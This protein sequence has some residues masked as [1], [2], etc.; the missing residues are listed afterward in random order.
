MSLS[1]GE[2]I[3]ALGTLGLAEKVVVAHASLRAFGWVEGGAGTVVSALLQTCGA[4]FMPTHTYKTMLTPQ[5]GPPDNGIDYAR[6]AFWNRLA[7]PYHPD[8]PADVLMGII[9][10]TLRQHPRARRSMHP[11]LSFAGVNA[12]DIL[13]T[14][15]LENPFAPLRAAA[16]A[17]A[18]VLLLG[19]NHTVNTSIHL[20]EKL[21]GRKTFTR[22]ALTR[23]GVITCPGFPGCSA[24]FEAIEPDMRPYTTTIAIGPAQVRAMPMRALVRTV[25]E[26]IRRD[27]LAL[28][29]PW[30]DCE[31]CQ[32]SRLSLKA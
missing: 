9:P 3:E 7:E 6:A 27:P 4:L 28:L 21:T 17:D 25:I 32:A 11:I 2:L 31:R 20:A 12:E 18:W 24:G 10:E 5:S 16:D 30:T 22:W 26:A 19:V 1:K 13:A 23:D 15:S 8:M 14:Q 29:C